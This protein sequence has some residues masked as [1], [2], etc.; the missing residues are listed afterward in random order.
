MPETQEM[1][2]QYK[3]QDAMVADPATARDVEAQ[4]EV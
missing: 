2:M 1:E 3:S 4:A